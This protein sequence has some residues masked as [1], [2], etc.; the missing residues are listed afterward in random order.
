[1]NCPE[2]GAV[3]WRDEVDVGVGI[4]TSPW[5]CSECGWDED[6][7]FPMTDESWDKWLSE[8]PSP[9]DY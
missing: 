1:M 4:I 9:C 2:C 6:Q 7:S 5:M 3:C 8:G